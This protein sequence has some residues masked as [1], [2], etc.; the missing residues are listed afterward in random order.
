VEV[1][2]SG[3]ALSHQRSYCMSSSVNTEIGDC[4]ESWCVTGHSSELGGMGN[5]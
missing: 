4:L 5:E 3:I 1:W 2:C